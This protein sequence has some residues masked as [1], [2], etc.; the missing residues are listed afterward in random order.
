[1]LD[2]VAR[3]VD[4]SIGLQ[5]EASPKYVLSVRSPAWRM[6]DQELSR[7]IVS[8]V[9]DAVHSDSGCWLAVARAV[10]ESIGLQCE[11]S[12]KHVLSV[13]LREN[14]LLAMCVDDE[15]RCHWS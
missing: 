2:A 4:E 5:C 3:A 9:Y 12:P 13:R 10:D 8:V 15:Q 11:A 6:S 1:M 7:R 14:E